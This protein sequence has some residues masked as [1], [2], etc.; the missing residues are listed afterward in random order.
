VLII[1]PVS[2]ISA[3]YIGHFGTDANRDAAW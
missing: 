3:R 1:L 2:Q